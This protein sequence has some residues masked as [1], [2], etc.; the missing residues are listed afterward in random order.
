MNSAYNLKD[1]GSEF[2]HRVLKIEPKLD[3]TLILACD[4]IIKVLSQAHSVF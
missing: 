1:T 4:T 2:F 3:D